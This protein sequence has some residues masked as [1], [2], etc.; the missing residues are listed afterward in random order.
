MSEFTNGPWVVF[1]RDDGKFGIESKRN[2]SVVEFSLE[3]PGGIPK[4]ADAN[5]IAAAP[6]MYVAIR[7]M[8]QAFDVGQES[9]LN[10]AF[11]RTLLQKARGE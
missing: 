2:Y 8:V 11:Y 10:L 5:L 7:E 9:D 4:L 6:E 1:Y 3:G